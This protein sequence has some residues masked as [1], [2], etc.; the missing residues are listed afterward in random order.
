[1]A[2]HGTVQT[3]LGHDATAAPRLLRLAPLR[4]PVLKPHLTAKQANE[5]SV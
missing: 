1:M 3:V 4:S 5:M 2:D